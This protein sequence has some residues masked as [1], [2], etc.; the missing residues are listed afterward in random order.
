MIYED[1]YERL[2]R[3]L[4]MEIDGDVFIRMRDACEALRINPNRIAPTSTQDARM[5][6]ESMGRYRAKRSKYIRIGLLP[7]MA[8]M[9]SRCRGQDVRRFVQDAQREH[10]EAKGSDEKR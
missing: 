3:A 10:R 8:A 6:R 9:Y 2:C 7:D 4:L 5:V 1:A